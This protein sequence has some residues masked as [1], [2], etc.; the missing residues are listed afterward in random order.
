MSEAAV[1]EFR[2]VKVGAAFEFLDI[3]GVVW[4]K[5]RGG[6]RSGRGGQLHSCQPNVLVVPK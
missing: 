2:K 6:F 5:C 3:I 4:V 1:I